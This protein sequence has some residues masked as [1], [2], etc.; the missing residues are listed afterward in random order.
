MEDNTFSIY[1]ELGNEVKCEIINIFILPETKKHYM[2]YT[3]KSYTEDKLN[4]YA[5]IFD[6][7]DDT[8]FEEVTSEYEWNE[9]EKILKELGDEYAY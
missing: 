4:I 6:P 8:I 2:L 3:D 1:D 7:N 5:A 9:I